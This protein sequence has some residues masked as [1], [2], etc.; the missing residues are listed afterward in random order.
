M[1][2]NLIPIIKNE[3]DVQT[4]LGLVLDPNADDV[5]FSRLLKYLIGYYIHLGSNYTIRIKDSVTNGIVSYT[6][7]FDDSFLKL[8]YILH[9]GSSFLILE[10]GSFPVFN[11]L[12]FRE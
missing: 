8:D 10:D 3:D 12:S 2:N 4:E 1:N 6:T 11:V 7:N 9:D 5:Y